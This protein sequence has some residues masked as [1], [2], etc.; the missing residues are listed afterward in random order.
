M[1]FLLPDPNQTV[2]PRRRII[3]VAA[4][5]LLVLGVFA[6]RP[7][8][9][10]LQTFRARKLAAQAETLAAQNQPG[11]AMETARRALRLDPANRRALR[12]AVA[13][14]SRMGAARS[15]QYWRQLAGRPNLSL[16]ERQ[17]LLGAALLLGRLD[18]A[19][20]Q[21][22]ALL[23]AESPAA[24][25]LKLAAAYYEMRQDPHRAARAYARLL[26]IAPNDTGAALALGRLL[27]TSPNPEEQRA[28]KEHLLRQ[29]TASGS[30]AEE[31]LRI[32]DAANLLNQAEAA[33][34]LGTA[35]ELASADPL[36][37][38][39]FEVRAVPYR[40]GE[41]IGR[42]TGNPRTGTNALKLARW[43]NRHDA[44]E[45]TLELLPLERAL[46]ERD[47]FLLRLDAA[48]ALGRWSEV[49]AELNHPRSPLDPLRT[50]LYRARAASELGG[51]RVPE[52]LW[53]NALEKAA[54]SPTGLALA[55]EYARRAGETE[56]AVEAWRRLTRT[57]GAARHAYE[58]LIEVLSQQGDTRGL[59]E[60]FREMAS[61]YPEDPRVKND[62]AYLNLLLGEELEASTRA[63]E[64]LVRQSPNHLSFRT[65]L[66]L[67]RLRLG[68]PE[69]A[70]EVYEG[71]V[72]Q[73]GDAQPGWQAVYV[74]VRRANQDAEAVRAL[75]GT[76]PVGRLKP[77][78]EALLGIPL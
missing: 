24:P 76:V 20:S 46:A 78:E 43:L 61:R 29:A 75:A 12:V 54:E 55:A 31:A 53:A 14:G 47:L 72:F 67:G 77:E 8:W 27:I 28:G 5:A 41:I 36:L 18:L 7:M 35:R 70:L 33:I 25:T 63:A 44:F 42:L 16:E 3:F 40:R 52:L 4:A 30:Q 60:I 57:D 10:G 62:L 15:I 26:E 51:E 45:E 17:E 9:E 65:T 59:R 73:W 2:N 50:S 74:A 22:N 49:E 64:E 38:A 68:N 69:A 13:A 32:L 56:Q 19:S 71:A 21:L 66:A 37:L 6:A 58:Q 11:P 34:C 1:S 48:A 23:E 39:A